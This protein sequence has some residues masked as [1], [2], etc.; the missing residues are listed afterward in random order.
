[1]RKRVFSL[2]IVSLFA[3]LALVA[4]GSPS[5]EIQPTVTRIPDAANAPILTPA[6]DSVESAATPESAP[7]EATPA[8]D[9]GG[10]D[11]VAADVTIVSHD[12][13]F[14]PNAVTIA[15][16][17]PVTIYLDFDSTFGVNRHP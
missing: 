10:E 4:C 7:G 14:E 8:P 11:A 5:E 13:Y 15:S 1:M 6:G 12:I 2:S 3:V 9:A 16:G 17:A